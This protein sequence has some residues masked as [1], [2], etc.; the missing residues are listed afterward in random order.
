MN[1]CKLLVYYP[2]DFRIFSGTLL[3]DK[4]SKIKLQNADADEL[5]PSLAAKLKWFEGAN[6]KYAFVE[7]SGG[8]DGVFAVELKSE[9]GTENDDSHFIEYREHFEIV[10]ADAAR[11][12][13]YKYITDKVNNRYRSTL[14][15]QIKKIITDETLT[16]QYLFKLLLQ[17]DAKMEELL[18]S[19]KKDDEIEGLR[20]TKMLSF[21]GGGLSFLYQGSDISTGDIIYIQSMPKNGAGINFA[22]ICKVFNVINTG[23]KQICEAGYEYLDESTKETIIHYIF[24]KDR[25]QLKRKRN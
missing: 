3:S 14:A 6:S 10:K 15:T 12:N 22:A 25:E 13:D 9:I 11:I 7:L 17:I 23:E 2:E 18:D 1:S 21:G 5:M 16:N 24:Q 19:L 8:E 4:P 20:E